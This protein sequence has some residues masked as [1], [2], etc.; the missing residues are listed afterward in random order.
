MLR[1]TLARFGALLLSFA[2]VAAFVPT[3]VSAD[4]P[5]RGMLYLDGQIVRTIGLP[6]SVPHGGLDPLYEFTNG[7]SGQL[8]VATYGPGSPNFHGGLWAVSL[9]TFN[10]GVTPYLLTFAQDVLDAQAAGDVTITRHPELDN[11][12][13]VLR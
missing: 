1:A 4:A 7:V 3:S 6:A 10:A 12:C 9:V 5:P 13:P 8:S 2:L 11:R